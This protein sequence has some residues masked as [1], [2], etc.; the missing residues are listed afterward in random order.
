MEVYTEAYYIGSVINMRS[1]SGYCIFLNGNLVT[2]RSK[3]QNV[4]T[5]LVQR[6]D[7]ELWYMGWIVMAEIILNDLKVT[8]EESMTL[9]CDNK[10]ATS[11]AHSPFQNEWTTHIDIDWHFIKEKL[12]RGLITA[13]LCRM[14][15]S[16][17]IFVF[18]RSSHWMISWSH[19]QVGMI[20]IHSPTCGECWLSRKY[21]W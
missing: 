3:K 9:Y 15:A 13:L 5:C 6:L 19:L 14:W 20:D 2:W 10:W 16:I 7:F 21:S 18:K 12:D 4:I 17:S 8:C 1:S 11:I